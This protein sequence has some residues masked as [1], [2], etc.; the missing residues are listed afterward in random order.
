MILTEEQAKSRLDSPN[1][2]ASRFSGTS[3]F[4][5]PPKSPK[6]SKGRFIRKP[7]ERGK[8]VPKFIKNTAAILNRTKSETQTKI[9]KEFGIAQVSASNYKNGKNGV[10]E[11]K[12]EEKVKSIRDAAIEK[13][14][15]SMGCIT[16]EKMDKAPLGDLS[17]V[18]ARMSQIIER[19]LP[20][21]IDNPGR[22]IQL[23]IHAPSTKAEKN[24]NVIDV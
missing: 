13:L 24:Y 7:G 23:V 16:P 11:D 21:D 2:L 15:Y 5:L 22:N 17:Q 8:N 4:Q 10:E 9:G 18:A 20:K 12:I 1:N 14:M 19:T 3:V 6:D